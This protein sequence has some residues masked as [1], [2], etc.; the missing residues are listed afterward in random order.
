MDYLNE[1]ENVIISSN[2]KSKTTKVKGVNHFAIFKVDD[3]QR[4][5]MKP[6]RGKWVM[7]YCQ[8]RHQT[9][10]YLIVLPLNHDLND[11]QSKLLKREFEMTYDH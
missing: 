4:G 2:Y 1:L 7:M 3:L 5:N 8:G 9:K 6:Y 11:N 10:F